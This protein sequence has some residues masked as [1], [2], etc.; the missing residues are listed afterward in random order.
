VP[1]LQDSCKTPNAFFCSAVTHSCCHL[2][3]QTDDVLNPAT[4]I[5]Q[6]MAERESQTKHSW[7]FDYLLK[8]DAAAS[9]RCLSIV[10]V[11]R[12]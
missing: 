11:K 7:T 5:A 8:A 3:L 4:G 6:E 2:P 9:D 1:H 12:L 10:E